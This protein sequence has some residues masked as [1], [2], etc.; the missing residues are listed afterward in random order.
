MS[1]NQLS[2]FSETD[3]SLP[4]LPAV[5]AFLPRCL[6]SLPLEKETGGACTLLGIKMSSPHFT[7][8]KP[9]PTVMRA[10]LLLPGLLLFPPAD[11]TATCMI[12]PLKRATAGLGQLLG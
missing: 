1:R 12:A 11:A 10:S 9:M 2:K 3:G 6:F 8:K 5:S 4:F 7:G